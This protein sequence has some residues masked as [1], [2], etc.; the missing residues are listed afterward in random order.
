MPEE[1]LVKVNL[2]H[3]M[4]NIPRW[5]RQAVFGRMLKERLKNTKMRI[6]KTLNEKIWASKDPKVRLKVVK[7][8]KSSRAEAVE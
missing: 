1:K 8:D 5:R 3:H 7:D 6:A 4:R 2:R